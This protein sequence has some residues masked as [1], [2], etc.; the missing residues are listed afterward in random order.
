MTNFPRSVFDDMDDVYKDMD[1]S[2]NIQINEQDIISLA[3]S[4]T[5][6]ELRQKKEQIEEKFKKVATQLEANKK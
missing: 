3:E 4:K 1:I 2:S 5:P 6:E